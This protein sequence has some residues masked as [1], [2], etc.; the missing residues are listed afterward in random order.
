[1]DETTI[2]DNTITSGK[3][4]LVIG[5]QVSYD[6]VNNIASFNPSA[7][8][9]Y[10]NHYTVTVK[11][12]ASGVKRCSRQSRFAQTRLG[13]SR[14]WINQRGTGPHAFLGKWGS[15]GVGNG[16]FSSQGGVAGYIEVD[17][18]GNIYV[19]DETTSRIQKF[20]SAGV[21]VTKW[22]SQG[23]DDGEFFANL[24]GLA[25]DN[26]NNVY[27]G[28]FG[29]S[30]IQKF[31]S[32]GNFLGKWGS[33]GSGD[34][35]FSNARD[36]DV[37]SANNVYVA[38]FGNSRIQKFDSAGNF[39]AKWG[40]SGSGDGQFSGP[41]GIS[42]DSANNVYV[43]DYGSNRIQKFDSA[44][45]FLGKWGSS[46]S[47]DGQFSGPYGIAVDS[48]NKVYVADF[49]NNR[50]QMFDSAGNFLAKWGTAG[51]ADGQFDLPSGVVVEP[52]SGNVYVFD[53]DNNRVQVFSPGA[54]ADTDA[55]TV[56][57]TDPTPAQTDIS[58]TPCVC[59]TFSEDMDPSTINTNTIVVTG[60][61]EQGVAGQISYD[62]ATRIASFNPTSPL[63][64]SSQYSAKALGG[65]TGVKDLA[66]NPMA[67]QHQ[68][69]FT[70]MAQPP[71]STDPHPFIGRWGSIGS[72]N[73]QFSGNSG[74]IAADSAGNIY[75]T[76]HTD[77]NVQKFKSD[78]T[79][80]TKWGTD[81]NW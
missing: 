12:G 29:N 62:A 49:N 36:F 50:I 46:G 24:H 30:R 41:V 81:G 60:P 42:V 34:G 75:V 54:P 70:T 67:N 38:D 19:I 78:G 77:N 76:D 14:L 47:G 15:S 73:G 16:Q 55:P 43:S 52:V 6:P 3:L 17:S 80:V 79:F 69:I 57:L 10:D 13:D 71:T 21:F 26:A 72:G 18:A 68:W 27:V 31:D 64:F 35:Q 48:A 23:A 20:T 28:D 45:N 65:T 66:G 39:L 33:L 7:P 74:G 51:P 22:G 4:K 58:T 53:S 11:G 5:G 44:G 8:L 61:G 37:D 59:I 56:T 25:V 9:G 2:N 40:S 63:A 1:M 32:A